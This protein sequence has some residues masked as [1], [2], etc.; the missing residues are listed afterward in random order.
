MAL[1]KDALREM[2]LAE[3]DTSEAGAEAEAILTL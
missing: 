3:A 2:G 1:E